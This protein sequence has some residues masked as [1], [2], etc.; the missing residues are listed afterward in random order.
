MNQSS[1]W[2]LTGDK[3]LWPT[4]NKLDKNKEILALIWYS[5]QL[6]VNKISLNK[7]HYQLSK[8]FSKATMVPFLHMVKLVQVKHIPWREVKQSKN[9]EVSFQERFNMLS[10]QSKVIVSLISGTPGVNFMVQVSML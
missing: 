4:Q 6:V 7:P 9:I 2:F 8:V 1:M 3:L 10:N 5:N